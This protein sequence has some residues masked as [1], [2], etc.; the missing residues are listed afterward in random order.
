LRKQEVGNSDYG[1]QEKIST[2]TLI[3]KIVGEEGNKQD[4]GSIFTL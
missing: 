3:V 2:A 1:K 4:T